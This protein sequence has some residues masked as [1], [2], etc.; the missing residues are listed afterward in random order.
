MLEMPSLATSTQILIAFMIHVVLFCNMHYIS[1]LSLFC[2]ATLVFKPTFS[3]IAW[4]STEDEGRDLESTQLR[5]LSEAEAI[6]QKALPDGST[7]PPEAAET[8]AP[9]E[10]SSQDGQQRPLV[11]DTKGNVVPKEA[12]VRAAIGLAA[13]GS[14][15]TEETTNT[16]QQGQWVTAS[17]DD[18]PDK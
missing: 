4:S 14:I 17:F 18:V 8:P 7:P 16:L 3:Q 10:G 11:S 5:N 6:S 12:L 1:I 9:N 13:A 15:V 2:N